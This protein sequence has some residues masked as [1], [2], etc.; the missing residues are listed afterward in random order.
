[1]FSP[2]G[3]DELYDLAADPYETANLISDPAYGKR[4]DAMVKQMWSKMA[5]I[6][7]ESLFGSHYATLRTAPVGPLAI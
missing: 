3:I 6:G 4:R 2:G 5:K 7:D 1:M